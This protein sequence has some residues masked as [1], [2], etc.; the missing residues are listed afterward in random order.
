MAITFYYLGKVFFSLS[1]RNSVLTSVSGGSKKVKHEEGVRVV[2]G[3][4]KVLVME[5]TPRLVQRAGP[6]P[7]ME[8]KMQI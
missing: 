2:V 5:G 4:L 6:G 7:F 1:L 3:Y 8:G